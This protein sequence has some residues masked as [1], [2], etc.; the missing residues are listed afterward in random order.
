M[1]GISANYLQGFDGT[2]FVASN[3]Q[4]E[5]DESRE[6]GVVWF[7]TKQEALDKIAILSNSAK[8]IEYKSEKNLHYRQSYLILPLPRW[9]VVY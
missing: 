6:D 9:H 4:K 3:G 7:D 2:L 1:Y 8:V 5:D